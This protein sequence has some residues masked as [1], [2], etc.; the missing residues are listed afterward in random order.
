MNETTKWTL[1]P[2]GLG[3]FILTI[4]GPEGTDKM[5]LDTDELIKLKLF[6]ST[7]DVPLPE[8]EL[9]L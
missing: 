7:V 6:L 9:P 2:N 4:T 8:G 1:T 3:L 5:W